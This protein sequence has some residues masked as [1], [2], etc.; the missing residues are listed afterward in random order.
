MLNKLQVETTCV[1]VTTP[2]LL[3]MKSFAD[4]LDVTVGYLAS[5][6]NDVGINRIANLSISTSRINL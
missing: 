3:D 5:V 2:D 6:M 4:F 1:T